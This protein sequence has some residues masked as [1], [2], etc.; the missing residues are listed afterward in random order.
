M[1]PQAQCI[2]DNFGGIQH[3]YNYCIKSK[4]G[5]INYDD[6]RN[7]EPSDMEGVKQSAAAIFNYTSALVG[8]PRNAIAEECNG[9]L[10]NRY[11][12][13]SG[14]KCK[15]KP[16]ENVHIYVNNVADYN[17][18]TSRPESN[19]GIIPAAINSTFDIN[20]LNLIRALYEDPNQNCI[21]ANLKCHVVEKNKL[22]NEETETV[23]ISVRQYDELL[24][25]GQIVPTS[26][27]IAE[28]ETIE[29]EGYTNLHE[30]IHN[31]LDNNSYLLPTKNLEIIQD[32]SD[33]EDLLFNL[34]YLFLSVFLLFLIFKIINKK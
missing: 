25:K 16:T 31:Y 11:I 4:D 15:N 23:P 13:K 34:Y 26:E 14:M 9:L 29:A 20:G 21:N 10:G 30:S 18:L 6:I 28:R 27:Q 22:I 19:L 1:S 32:N 24:E 33:D 7:S 2:V 3:P 17:Y 5:M 12:L 8:D